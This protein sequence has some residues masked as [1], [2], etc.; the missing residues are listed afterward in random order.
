MMFTQHLSLK[1]YRINSI[2]I[3]PISQAENEGLNSKS[4]VCK[5]VRARI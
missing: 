3:M 5:I 4:D 1:A 2:I